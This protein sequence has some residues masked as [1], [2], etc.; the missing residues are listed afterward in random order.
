MQRWLVKSE[1]SE[2]S[3]DDLVADGR[4]FWDGVRNYQARNF[5]CELA[6]GD[7]VFFY[8]SNAKPNVIAGICSVVAEAAPDPTAF[9]PDDK[10]FD[11]KSDPDDPRWFGVEVAPVTAFDPPITREAL[12]EVPALEGMELLRRGSRRSVQSVGDVEW[13]TVLALGG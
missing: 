7:G 10:H 13:K 8:H 2:Y 5:L 3:W 9:N 4:T 11:A 1:P 6:E 12:K